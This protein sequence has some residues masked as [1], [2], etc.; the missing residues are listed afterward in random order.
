MRLNLDL[1]AKH[2]KCKPWRDISNTIIPTADQI[3]DYWLPPIVPN[4]V[5]DDFEEFFVA[6]LS[7]KL[8]W[9]RRCM[10]SSFSKF[11]VEFTPGG[12]R[13]LPD[14]IEWDGKLDG[15]FLERIVPL[16]QSIAECTTTP[17]SLEQFWTLATE[18]CKFTV[19]P[20]SPLDI[21]II[22]AFSK[23]PMI[24]IPALAR[25]LGSS[26]KTT[27]NRWNR[28]RRLNICRIPAQV[29]YH[30]LG[31]T[32]VFIELHDT[33]TS[34]KSPYILSYIEL[35]GN[36]RSDLYFM[37]VPEEQLNRLPRFLDFY[38]GNTYTLYLVEDIGQT[39]EFT[40]YQIEKECWNIDWRKLFIGAHLLHHSDAN[41]HLEFRD[42]TGQPPHRLYIPD[43]RD[44][45]LIPLLASDA[46]M[47]LETLASFA[48]MSV[49]QASRRKS[50]LIEHGVLQPK[51]LIRRIG[52]LEDVIVRVKE[53]D[54]QLLGIV[55][56]LP[57][58]W[59]RQ[60]TEYHTGEH[61]LFIYA[62]LPPGSFA[63]IRYYLSKYLHTNSDVYI[64]GPENGGWP[65]RFDTYDSE[66]CRWIWKE[67]IVVENSRLTAFEMRTKPGRPEMTEKKDLL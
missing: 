64:S 57:Q 38:F 13:G 45:L 62:T 53:N 24:T 8:G 46:R 47:K 29:N 66:K 67:P 23:M 22:K 31:L 32:P 21:N 17:L 27:R 52:L 14:F 36:E 19:F 3:L 63:L 30:S 65:L 42:D 54:A 20:L 51:P 33:E 43:S 48:G 11:K 12:Y 25:L 16:L 55:N 40:H 7:G 56:E 2:L 18:L 34:I 49:S 58:A 28:L 50:K 4:V 6:K 5:K 37:A 10:N 26:Y 61:E 15:Q 1:V 59:I 39:I 41:Q 60:L 9:L 35:A 44:K